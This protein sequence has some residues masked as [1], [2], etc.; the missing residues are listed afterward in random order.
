MW[1]DL[2]RSPGNENIKLNAVRIIDSDGS[3]SPIV[4]I[5]KPVILE[6]EY[7]CLQ[8]KVQLY[9]NP[10]IPSDRNESKTIFKPQESEVEIL[11][12]ISKLSTK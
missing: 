1:A 10:E 2:E 9:R 6:M 7:R 8:V 4:D 12:V 5:Q 11:P 3:T